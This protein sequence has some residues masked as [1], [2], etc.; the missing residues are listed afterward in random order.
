MKKIVAVLMLILLLALTGLA[1]FTV[2]GSEI[3][4]C[5]VSSVTGEI[6]QMT[7]DQPLA[8]GVSVLQDGG[9]VAEDG[10][11]TYVAT[12]WIIVISAAF[13]ASILTVV[14]LLARKNQN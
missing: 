12:V 8:D 2:S 13:A 14:I 1:S 6:T 3:T 4:E 9:E 11:N 5:A 10:I 7:T